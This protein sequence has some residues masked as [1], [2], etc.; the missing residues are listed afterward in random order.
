MLGTMMQIQ[1]LKL[2]PFNSPGAKVQTIANYMT[3]QKPV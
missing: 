3:K 2:K 1:R